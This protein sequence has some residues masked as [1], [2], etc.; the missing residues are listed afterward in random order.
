[1]GKG[2]IFGITIVVIVALGFF[3][4]SG[5]DDSTTGTSSSS[6]SGEVSG[7]SAMPVQGNEDVDEIIVEDESGSD[8][9]AIS[10]SRTITMTLSGFS[11]T[12]LEI[13]KGESVTFVNQGSGTHWPATDV[14]PSHSVYPGSSIGKCN[15]TDKTR[16]FD[17]C[18]G[19]SR[20]GSFTFTFNEVGNWRYH[21]HLSPGLKGT[22]I[23]R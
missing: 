1:M 3:L 8:E 22:V 12:S 20:G 7:G 14:H 23:V 18:K 11:P 19:I 16:I 5:G 9:G 17:A 13:K 6:G 21:D 4:F 10:G 15:T 2:W